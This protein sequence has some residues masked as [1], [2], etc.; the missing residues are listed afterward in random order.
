VPAGPQLVAF[1]PSSHLGRSHAFYAGV[2]GLNRTEATSQANE[3]DAHG[4]PL[5]VTLVP[6]H[7]P[8]P[9]TVM[10]WRVPDVRAAMS[11]LSGRGVSFK[12]YEGFKQDDHGIWVAPS[13][14]QVCWFEDPDGNIMSLHQPP[15]A[16]AS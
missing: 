6:D 8:S 16:Q 10:G 1:M 3:Y 11:D 9:Y 2:L 4:T 14:A 12:R 5:R 7:E 15:S 13:G